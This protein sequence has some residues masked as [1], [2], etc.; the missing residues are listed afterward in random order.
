MFMSSAQKTPSEPKRHDTPCNDDNILKVFF[1]KLLKIHDKR[2]KAKMKTPE[3]TIKD[4]GE[5]FL[6]RENKL[7][8][9]ERVQKKSAIQTIQTR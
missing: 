6:K 7:Y 8:K 9:I 5:N 3:Q 1:L 4:M 2:K